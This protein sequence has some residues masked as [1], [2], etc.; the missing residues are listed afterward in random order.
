MTTA[1]LFPD[2]PAVAVEAERKY[3][4]VPWE[5][6][7]ALRAALLKRGCPTTLCLDPENRQARLELWPGVKPEAVL[8][9]LEARR[10]GPRATTAAPTVR[11]KPT[12]P[13]ITDPAEHI[14]V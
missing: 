8:A 4:S 7:D 10:P 12:V 11:E 5:E 13:T 14:C 1:A 3:V 6:A 9:V 2:A